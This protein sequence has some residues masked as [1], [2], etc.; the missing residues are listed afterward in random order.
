[1]IENVIPNVEIDSQFG[2]G[3][4][5]FRIRGIGAREYS[6]N[7]SSTVGVYIDEVAHPYTIT[8]QGA[9]FDIDRIEVLRGPQG[10]LY[11]RNTT[12]GAVNI[13]TSAPT[14]HLTAGLTAEAGTFDRY[15]LEGFV[16]GPLG[17][18]ARGRLAFVREIGGAWQY[19]RD[20]GE[21]LGDADRTAVRGRVDWDVAQNVNVD[22]SATYTRDQSDGLGFRLLAPYTVTGGG[23]T[24]PADT[25]WRITGWQISSDLAQIAGVGTDAN[26]FRDNEGLDGSAIVRVD[27]GSVELTSV[28]AYQHFERNEYNDWDGTSANE[29]DVFFFNEI[30]AFSQEVRLASTGDGP[31]DWLVGAHYANEAN[32]GGFYTEFRGRA[33][34]ILTP[35]E[36]DVEAVGVFA[37]LTYAL[38]ERLRL[39]GGLRYESEERNLSTPGTITGIY[40]TMNIFPTGVYADYSTDLSEVSGRVAV[41]YDVSDD[42]LLYASFARGVKSGGF[43]TYN[44]TS[45][46]P[47]RPEI[48][49]AYE[50][51]VKTEWLDGRLR[52][53]AA[54][55]YYDYQDQQVQGLEYDTIQ[56]RLGKITNVP[57]SHIYGFE[58]DLTWEIFEG[59]NISQY[60][61]IKEGE[62]D[63]YF[64]IDGTATDAANP[65]GGPWTNIIANDRSGERLGFPRETY[66]GAISYD[67]NVGEYAFRAETNYNY[68]GDLYSVTTTSVIPA[69]WLANASIGVGPEDGNW[70]FT[71]W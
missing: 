6:S 60:A 67:W 26:P 11:G 10:T 1:D 42:A 15:E 59:L 38:T 17:D 55:F 12:G 68:R 56:G 35:Y 28:T 70:R 58:V 2:G 19:N 49:L 46:L 39:S 45:A 40:P 7:N 32:D 61:S 57:E 29:S 22:L 47:F 21:E 8:T 50:T 71:V 64:A 31:L 24:Y 53:N 62:Y 37:N 9:L 44:A 52:L 43:T 18:S 16:S 4:P 65:P 54:A 66:G 41:E 27:L 30:D 5:Q 48:V 23:P 25:E 36:Q 3:Q 33:D 51:G 63:E 14:D 34:I 20:T 13:I 69:Y